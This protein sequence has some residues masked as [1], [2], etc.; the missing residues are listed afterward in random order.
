MKLPVLSHAFGALL[1]SITLGA[2]ANVISIVD[3]SFHY[4]LELG[5]DIPT[6]YED[7]YG[8]EDWH[9]SGEYTGSIQETPSPSISAEKYYGRLPGADETT[10]VRGYTKLTYHPKEGAFWFST[11]LDPNDEAN[12]GNPYGSASTLL[13]FVF[14]YEGDNTTAIDI[15]SGGDIGGATAPLELWDL[16]TGDYYQNESVIYLYLVSGHRYKLANYYEVVM[17]EIERDSYRNL[18]ISFKSDSQQNVTIVSEPT[19]LL[20][21]L[22]GLVGVGSGVI[23]TKPKQIRFTV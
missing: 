12:P 3:E 21:L 14:D 11:F 6:Y 2:Y 17:P 19:S 5:I 16:T 23:G 10:W 4:T 18:E 1:C 13:E 8:I 15:I 22:L 7:E 20:L 9:Y